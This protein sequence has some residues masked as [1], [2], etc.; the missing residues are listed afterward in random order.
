[1]KENFT[2]IYVVRFDEDEYNGYNVFEAYRSL[3]SAKNRLREVYTQ[4]Y[5]VPE[6]SRKYKR[7]EEDLEENCIEDFGWIETSELFE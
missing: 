3:E 7:M 4:S 2:T 1:M 5:S 6:G